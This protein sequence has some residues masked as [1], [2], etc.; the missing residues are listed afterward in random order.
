MKNTG[1]HWLAWLLAIVLLTGIAG[2]RKEK[3][4]THGAL[5]TSLVDA[6]GER[7]TA[8]PLSLPDGW[9]MTPGGGALLDPESGAV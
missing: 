3:T 6:A 5:D 4:P 8:A 7:Y 1:K 9:T 2:C